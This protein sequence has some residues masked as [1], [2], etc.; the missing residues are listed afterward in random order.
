MHK[1]YRTMTSIRACQFTLATLSL[2]TLAACGG[3]DAVAPPSI[4]AQPANVTVAEGGS[5][6]FTVAATGAGPLTFAWLNAADSSPI[7]GAT[8]A[9]LSHSG[10]SLA[11]S[12]KA[13]KARVSN[14]GGEVLSA[15]ATLT[16]NERAWSAR[17]D[18]AGYARNSAVVVD[19]NGHTHLLSMNGDATH[20]DVMAHLK[21]KLSDS[22]QANFLS[23][24]GELQAM[25]VLSD[26]TTSIATAA[27]GSGHVMAVWHRNGLVGAALYTP[28]SNPA[29][30]GTWQLLPT[31]ISSFTT[32]SA[33]DPAVAA[34]GNT[35][36]EIVW[37]EQTGS[38]EE[39]DIVARHYTIANNTLGAIVGLEASSQDTQAPRVIADAAG[40]MLAAWKFAGAAV[41]INRRLQGS[42][43]A[44]ATTVVE[45]P[46]YLLDQLKGNAAGKG[47]VLASDRVGNASFIQLD[48]AAPN[49]MV[50]AGGVNAFGSAADAFVFADGRIQVF[51]VSVNTDAGNS[52]RLF[53]WNFMPNT[54]WS[55]A[56][57]VSEISNHD[58]IATG[59]GVR[60]PYV[61]GADA[62]GNL[63]LTW[64]ERDTASGG[65]GR[66][67][68]RRLHGGLNQ[69]R[70]ITAVAAGSGTDHRIPIAAVAADGSGTIVFRNQVSGGFGAANFR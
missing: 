24:A 28:A 51:G 57:P 45:G 63:L 55:G 15:N 39:H 56:N 33:R 29:N 49:P 70:D 62:Q 23:Q 4:A 37:R 68:T 21:L 58:F 44:T 42:D 52:S 6:T 12:G 47:I 54:G 20:A 65:L 59:W 22:T 26:A 43:W 27:N 2:A 32:G 36:F 16:V 13:F 53:H 18:V 60:N 61:A 8:A 41:V 3:D 10:V 38:N 40:N 66:V 25:D 19:S 14:V 7:S 30:A 5:A 34:V 48:L 1:E 9:T 50:G 67:Q 69:W 35:G 31:R 11:D 17:F 64:E 46:N